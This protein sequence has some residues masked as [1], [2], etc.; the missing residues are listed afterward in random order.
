MTMSTSTTIGRLEVLKHSLEAAR[1]SQNLTGELLPESIRPMHASHLQ[2]LR[3]GLDI[4]VKAIERELTMIRRF[5]AET[6]T[7]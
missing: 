6:I 3:A 4:A 7:E 5:E 1:D 2:G